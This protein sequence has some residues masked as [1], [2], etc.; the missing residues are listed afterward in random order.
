MSLKRR[1]RV[2]KHIEKGML[3]ETRKFGDQEYKVVVFPYHWFQ[4]L[5]EEVLT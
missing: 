5:K 2:I 3:T 1:T 4:E